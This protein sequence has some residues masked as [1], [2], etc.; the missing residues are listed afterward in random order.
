MENP[1][2]NFKNALLNKKASV[3]DLSP[4]AEEAGEK[5]RVLD[6]SNSVEEATD[7]SEEEY[8]SESTNSDNSDEEDMAFREYVRKLAKVEKE[9]KIQ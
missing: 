9:V 8:D 4:M 7:G 2:L 3:T 5:I 1:E 6:L